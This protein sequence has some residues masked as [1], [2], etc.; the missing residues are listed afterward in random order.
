MPV[1]RTVSTLGTVQAS[2]ASRP[3]EP[4]YKKFIVCVNKCLAAALLL[5]YPYFCDYYTAQCS[6]VAWNQISTFLLVSVLV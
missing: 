5:H 2:M 3:Q 4:K 1:S 6:V